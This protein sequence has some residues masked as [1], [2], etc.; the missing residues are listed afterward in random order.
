MSFVTPFH[1]CKTLERIEHTC[2]TSPSEFL[3]FMLIPDN[4]FNCN[5]RENFFTDIV[6][7]VGGGAVER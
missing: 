5:C 3:I 4:D 2:S 1:S 6:I 7:H